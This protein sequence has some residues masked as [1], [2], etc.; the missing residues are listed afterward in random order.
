M[1][2]NKIIVQ[3]ALDELSTL[4]NRINSLIAEG[5][6][7]DLVKGKRSVPL[8]KRFKDE[9]S[10][11]KFLKS[12]KDK[13]DSLIERQL[14]L[15]TKIAES[16]AITKFT[17]DGVEMTVAEALNRKRLASQK[18]DYLTN[19]RQQ[20]VNCER[21]I[22]INENEI[23]ATIEQRLAVRFGSDVKPDK[24]DQENIS[25]EV[26][27]DLALSLTDPNNIGRDI[28]EE[29][30]KLETFIGAVDSEMVICNS[31]TEIEL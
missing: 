14:M 29:I 8:I 16:N 20:L 19:M 10:L 17:V 31:R 25:K 28:D 21:K 24:D 1:T 15:H 4:S 22:M 9:E 11:K 6:F 7:I 18:M 12:N 3:R 27:A 30:D 23:Q 2:T 26:R 13:V 5:R